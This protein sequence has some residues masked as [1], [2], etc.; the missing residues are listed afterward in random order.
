MYQDEGDNLMSNLNMLVA[1]EQGDYSKYQDLLSQYN[2]DR[3]FDYGVYSDDRNYNYQLSR[4]AISDSRYDDETAYNRNVYADETAYNRGIYADETAYN[5]AQDDWEKANYASETEYN[6]ALAKAQTLAA[7]G[8]FSGYKAL[9]YTDAEIS[10]LKTAYDRAQALSLLSG[11]SSG[12]TTSRSTG[13]NTGGT[14]DYAGLF[15]AAS[16]S[17]NPQNYISSNYE[18]YGFTSNA[19]LW[20]QYQ[21]EYVY[22]E[23]NQSSYLD[24]ISPT[25]LEEFNVTAEGGASM[26]TLNNLLDRWVA[27][28]KITE[29]QAEAL[30]V[31]MGL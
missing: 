15:Q 8:D 17:A 10:S 20:S 11:S 5:R 29:A 18:K 19:G 25:V 1:L 2:A 7:A 12:N 24:S 31:S 14:P 22:N 16:Q 27:Q 13:G 6:Q 28:G 23:K 30:A 3:S 26:T 21:D 9:G 4:D